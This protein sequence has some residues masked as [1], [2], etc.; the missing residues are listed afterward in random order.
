LVQVDVE[1]WGMLQAVTP[2]YGGDEWGA[3]VSVLFIHSM[4]P[5][6][7]VGGQLMRGWPCVRAASCHPVP[8]CGVGPVGPSVFYVSVPD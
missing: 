6:T 1:V 8:Q 7:V 2:G 3:C 5:I 4:D